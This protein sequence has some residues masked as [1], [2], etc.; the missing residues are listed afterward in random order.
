MHAIRRDTRKIREFFCA[1]VRIKKRDKKRS[2]LSLLCSVK[3]KHTCDIHKRSHLSLSLFFSFRPRKRRREEEGERRKKKKY[4]ERKGASMT[5]KNRGFDPLRLGGANGK[6]EA[7][8]LQT[9]RRP[10]LRFEVGERLEF[11]CFVGDNFEEEHQITGRVVGVHVK[12]NNVN[13][14][15]VHPYKAEVD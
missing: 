4:R 8:L 7:S 3:H 14:E 1:V 13:C 15:V 6:K 2:N 5:K 10:F 12:C 11:S 9:R